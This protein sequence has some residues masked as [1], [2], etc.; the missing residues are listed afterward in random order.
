MPSCPEWD[1]RTLVTH[2]G[3]VHRWAAT[4][5]AT[6]EPPTRDAFEMPPKDLATAELAAWLRTGA[7]QL[8]QTLSTVDLAGPTWHPFPLE[9]V[10][11]IWPRRQMIETAVHRCDAELAVGIDPQLDASVA[12]VGLQEFFELAL[13]R[14]FDREGVAVPTHS[15]HL[16]CTDDDLP[17]GSGEWIVWGDDGALKVEAVH[18][19]GDAALRGS[20]S[21]L[22]LVMTGRRDRACLDVVGDTVA[23]EAW[24][25]LPGL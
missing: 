22:L 16:H 9:Q 14:V 21:D 25:D 20:A 6:A 7:D 15:L 1:L 10:A 24:L 18:R 2:L 17:D 12:A 4:A 3:F 19:K 23:V 8:C 5:A 13:P 11:R